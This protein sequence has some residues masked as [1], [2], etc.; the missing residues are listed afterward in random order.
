[1][2]KASG[3]ISSSRP[4]KTSS[5]VR[6]PTVSIR[7]TASGENRNWPNEPDAVP[8]PKASERQLSGSSFP[9]DEITRLNEQPDSPK[10]ISTPLERKSVSGVEACAIMKMPAAYSSVPAMITRTVPKRSAM[11]PENGC[12]AP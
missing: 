10:P 1:M 4:A 7:P 9:N 12:A 5:V 2:A 3:T 6:Q 8:A 11:A